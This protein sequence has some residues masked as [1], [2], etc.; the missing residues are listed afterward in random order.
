MNV[1]DVSQADFQAQVLDRS[2]EVPVVVDFWAAWCGPCQQLMPVLTEIVESYGGEVV[3][4]K[5]DTD[6]EQALAGQY[7]VRSLPTVKIFKNGEAVD[8]FMGLQ[9]ESRIR[10]LI[11]RHIFR[12]SD[13]LRGQ[14]REAAEAGDNTRA[15]ELLTQANRLD[16]ENRGVL[17]DIARLDIEEGNL[18][19]ARQI[20]DSLPSD[21]EGAAELAAQ[22]DMAATAA[23][24]GDP[25]ELRGRIEADPADLDARQKLAAVL[26]STQ[27]YQGALEQ[28]LAILARDRGFDDDAG[29]RGLLSVFE[30]LG[31][32]HPLV[33]EYRRK[34]FAHLY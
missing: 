17:V 24:A 21:F 15:R 14:A 20:A 32:D 8:E 6:Q 12:E 25:D 27:D 13:K 7:G 34:M 28:Y 1:F 5:V 4:A 9:P 22:V 2:H 30:M 18:D 3:L 23:E 11:D 19:Q 29:R 16:P 10:A 26:I 31:S 33:K